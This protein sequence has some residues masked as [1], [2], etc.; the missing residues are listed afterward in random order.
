ME[1]LLGTPILVDDILNDTLGAKNSSPN[2][3]GRK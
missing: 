3:K 1:M 2:R